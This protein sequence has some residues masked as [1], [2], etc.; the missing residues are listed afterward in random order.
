MGGTGFH[1]IQSVFS[2]ARMWGGSVPLAYA[3]QGAVM[4]TRRRRTGL[5]VAQRARPIRAKRRR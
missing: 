3:M 2:W 5:A 1:K 4:L